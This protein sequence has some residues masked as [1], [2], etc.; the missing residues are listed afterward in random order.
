MNNKEIDAFD[1]IVQFVVNCC[2]CH[3]TSQLYRGLSRVY[4]LYPSS[5]SVCTNLGG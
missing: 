4:G 2:R 3:G 5:T 1:I